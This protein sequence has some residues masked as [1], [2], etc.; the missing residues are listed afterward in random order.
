MRRL[1]DVAEP[2]ELV[3]RR[4]EIARRRKAVCGNGNGP[5]VAVAFAVHVQMRGRDLFVVRIAVGSATQIKADE[6]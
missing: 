6:P 4:P 1:C 2:H 5:L 3:E